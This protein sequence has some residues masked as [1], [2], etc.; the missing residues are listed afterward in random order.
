MWELDH[1]EGWALKNWC[2]QMV[3]L[4]KTLKSPF[5]IKEIKPV[6]SRGNQPWVFNGRTDAKAEA[7]ILWSPDDKSQLTG[8]PDA[9]KDWGQEEKGTTEDE[10]TPLNQWTWVWANS[11]R[12]WKTGKP[13]MLQSMGSQRVRHDWTTATCW[14]CH[15]GGDTDGR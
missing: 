12:W 5:D 15:W 4:E 10:M 7:L 6:N 13:G 11:R 9:G 3:M 8:D 2:F 14:T 1:K